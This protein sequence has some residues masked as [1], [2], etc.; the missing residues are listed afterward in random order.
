[1]IKISYHIIRL[2]PEGSSSARFD[3]CGPL[4]DEMNNF[5][6]SNKFIIKVDMTYY[7]RYRSTPPVDT[8]VGSNT[9][10]CNKVY[11]GDEINLCRLTNP[12]SKLKEKYNLYKYDASISFDDTGVETYFKMTFL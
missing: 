7:L 5:L 6:R 12:A 9:Y 10:L 2:G 8:L 3:W 4:A 1:M 11:E